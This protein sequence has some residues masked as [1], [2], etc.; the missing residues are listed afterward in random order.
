MT[1]PENPPDSARRTVWRMHLMMA[2][3]W[4]TVLAVMYLAMDHWIQPRAA[5]VSAEGRLL[6][7]RQRDGHFYAD[8]TINGQSVRFLVD[9]GAS[10]IAVTDGLAQRAGLHGGEVT[11]FRTANGTR[12]GR[13]VRANHV[14]LGPLTV[15]NITVGTGYTGIQEDS[16]LLGQNFLRHFDV[17]IRD[18]VMELR[19]NTAH[20]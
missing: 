15:R 19:P 5:S 14:T 20:N 7:P 4:M 16:A 17:T 6:L 2:A 1:H 10:A 8:G 13:L 12:T 18:D 3:F 11:Q 9:T